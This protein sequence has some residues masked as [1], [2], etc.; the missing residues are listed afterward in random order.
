MAKAAKAQ[1]TAAA[2][3]SMHGW[4]STVTSWP[5]PTSAWAIASIGGTVPPASCKARTN[6]P[7]AIAAVQ[8]TTAN[9]WV[10]RSSVHA[11][12]G[13]EHVAA[14]EDVGAGQVVAQDG[15]EAAGGGGQPVGRLLAAGVVDLDV[16]RDRA[17]VG[18]A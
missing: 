17:V 3:R 2:R 10:E 5:R 14:L 11:L 15:T 9:R 13:G 4:P 12:D 6:R 1:P 16:D 18:D 7:G 8:H